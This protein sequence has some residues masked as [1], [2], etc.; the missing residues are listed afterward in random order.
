M[1]TITINF[2]LY[3]IENCQ[4]L[5]IPDKSGTRI[6]FVHSVESNEND[7]LVFKEKDI[8]TQIQ[9][10]LLN[11]DG[12]KPFNYFLNK[13]VDFTFLERSENDSL[14][15]W[16]NE[17]LAYIISMPEDHYDS[18]NEDDSSV[19]FKHFEKVIL[20]GIPNIPSKKWFE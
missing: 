9:I 10:N 16:D 3:K 8:P 15:D 18:N 17:M 2:D 5:D 1:E 4:V 11:S 6:R 14:P 19:I 20:Q 12:E 13:N 7:I